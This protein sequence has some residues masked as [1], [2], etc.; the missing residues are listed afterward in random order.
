V[1]TTTT[2]WHQHAACAEIGPAPFELAGYGHQYRVQI[3]TARAICAGCES[4]APCLAEALA[5]EDLT[6]IR[7][8]TTPPERAK[9]LGIRTRRDY[10]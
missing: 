1:S 2:A 3:A 5:I 7:A 4:V 6:T 10:A 8:G 9:M